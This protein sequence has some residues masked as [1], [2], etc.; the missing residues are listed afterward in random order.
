ML[1]TPIMKGLTGVTIGALGTLVLSKKTRLEDNGITTNR[2][3]ICI[4][5]PNNSKFPD[6]FGIVS[7]SQESITSQTKVVAGLRG[8][9][10]NGT[11]GLQLM[12]FGDLTDGPAS[13]GGSFHLAGGA[14]PTVPG[15]PL[16]FYRHA[17]DLGNVMT[18]EKG[19]GYSA[20]THPA[21][22]LFGE[23]NIFGR[24]CAVYSESNDPT[25]SLPKG[26]ILA[27]GVIARSNSFKNLPPA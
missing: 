24:G 3:A 9:N 13:L 4:M 7:F 10:P 5:Y 1:K 22:K 23:N 18:N 16:A 15:Q 11:F 2:Y 20:F 26:E 21:I 6:A 8:L 19:A 14:S 27:G 25:T 17:G 12:E